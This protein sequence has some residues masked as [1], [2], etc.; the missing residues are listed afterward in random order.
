[1]GNL[2][3]NIYLTIDVDVLEVHLCPGTG[4]P[5]PGGLAWWQMLRYLRAL[6]HQNDHCKLVGVDIVETVPMLGTQV[7][8]FVSARL[9]SKVLAYYFS[10]KRAEKSE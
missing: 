8:E 6:L 1:M 2:R 10:A 5:Q 9:L 3:G 4:T 7:N